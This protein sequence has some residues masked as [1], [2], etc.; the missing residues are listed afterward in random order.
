MNSLLWIDHS[1]ASRLSVSS[2]W[3]LEVCLPLIAL[4]A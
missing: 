1:G 4:N 2:G 3:R